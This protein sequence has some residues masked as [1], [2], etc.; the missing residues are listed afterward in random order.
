M[1]YHSFNRKDPLYEKIVS[2][3]RH[4]SITSVLDVGASDG[5]LLAL[6]KER[7][8][9]VTVLK[10]VE[11]DKDFAAQSEEVVQGTIYTIPFKNSFDLVIAKDVIEHVQ[12]N[13]K[14]LKELIRVTGKYLFLSAPGP[15]TDCAW[16]D[17]QHVRPYT[18]SSF[19]HIANDFKLSIVKI[20]AIK[21][22]WPFRLMAWL[23]QQPLADVAVYGFFEK[24]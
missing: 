19:R 21:R 3:I 8:P 14:A 5:Y 24:K 11:I 1:A 15:F 13:V 16:G 18:Q 7:C 12:D 2:F 4:H 22:L 10:G 23:W 9:S 20:S 6:I 17:Y